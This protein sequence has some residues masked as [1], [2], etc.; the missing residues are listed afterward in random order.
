MGR[1]PRLE[2]EA[3]L[4]GDALEGGGSRVSL[5]REQLSWPG[6]WRAAGHQLGFP[7]E[8]NLTAAVAELWS[9]KI[10]HGARVACE[11]AVSLDS[12]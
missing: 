6:R 9:K 5:S 8:R 7:Q 12:L 1:Q 10:R 4:L 2:R 3:A 11:Q